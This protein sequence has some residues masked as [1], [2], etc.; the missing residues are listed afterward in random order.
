MWAKILQKLAK[1]VMFFAQTK[2]LARYNVCEN[3]K[4]K[5]TVLVPTLIANCSIGFEIEISHFQLGFRP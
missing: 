3:P 4:E 2:K 5:L 1:S